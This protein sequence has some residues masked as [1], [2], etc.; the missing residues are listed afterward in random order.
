MRTQSSWSCAMERR[1]NSWGSCAKAA[2]AV[3]STSGVGLRALIFDN[4]VARMSEP[5]GQL[6]PA[7]SLPPLRANARIL[8]LPATPRLGFLSGNPP[9]T[10]CFCVEPGGIDDRFLSSVGL[11]RHCEGRQ[12][13]RGDG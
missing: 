1:T 7:R 9:G 8:L 11:S 13:T 12:A 4:T 10:R 3:M 6:V 2:G 5:G